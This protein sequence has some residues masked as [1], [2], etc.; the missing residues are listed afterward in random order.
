MKILFQR[1]LLVAICAIAAVSFGCQEDLPEQK[2]HLYDRLAFDN[3]VTDALEEKGFSIVAYWGNGSHLVPIPADIAALHGV[4]NETNKQHTAYLVA[5]RADELISIKYWIL[6]E[7]VGALTLFSTQEQT[8]IPIE[9]DL[10]RIFPGIRIDMKIKKDDT[11]VRNAGS[12]DRTK[13]PEV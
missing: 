12:P 3:G 9:S 2:N 8:V 1:S 4:L 5:E 10:E 11:E 7:C 13:D 6:D